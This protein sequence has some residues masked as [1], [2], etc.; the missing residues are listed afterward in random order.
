MAKKKITEISLSE[1]MDL[2]KACNVICKNYENAVKMY[3]GS[4]NTKANEHQL[5]VYYSNVRL[6]ILKEIEERLK[7]IE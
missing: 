2:E 5:F 3:D 7:N 1:L 4:I 6:K